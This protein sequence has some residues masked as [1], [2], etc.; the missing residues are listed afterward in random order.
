[1]SEAL[2]ELVPLIAVDDD[3]ELIPFARRSLPPTFRSW[4]RASIMRR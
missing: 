4:F 1:M 3:S 2:H